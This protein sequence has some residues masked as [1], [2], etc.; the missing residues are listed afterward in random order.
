MYVQSNKMLMAILDEYVTGH[1]DAKRALCVL[2]RRIQ[3]R[4]YQ[5][6]VKGMH[7]DYLIKPLKLLLIGASG[8]G[9]THAINTIKN[10]VGLP[11]ISVDATDLGPTGATSGVSSHKL[12]KMIWEEASHLTKVMPGLYPSMDEAI[13]STIVYIDEIDKLGTSFEA[14]GN[15]NKHTQS[16]F[17][18]L[19]D[20]AYDLSGVSFIFSG[21][22]DS[23]TRE[24]KK[25][26][27]LGF[28]HHVD[29]EDETEILD[30]QILKMGIIPELLG[31]IN[32]IV[33]LD[34]FSV[35]DFINIIQERILPK[36]MMDLA[37]YGVFDVSI[38]DDDVQAIAERSVRSGQG[39][40]YAHREIDRY[41]LSLEFEAGDAADDAPLFL[42]ESL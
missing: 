23:I 15:W 40:R 18:T 13:D 36:K 22:F 39:V 25:A 9:K 14:T 32:M 4:K 5:K 24:K 26:S 2:L 33:Q 31:R 16:N 29:T 28:T 30:E 20:D 3:M 42:G 11:V 10:H 19:F 1:A 27:K 21:A 7:D 41:F 12:A 38:G 34:V 8:T 37:A 17:L 6:Y 35:D